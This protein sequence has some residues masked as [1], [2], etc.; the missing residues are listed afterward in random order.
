MNSSGTVENIQILQ[1]G[2]AKHLRQ[3]AYMFS[4]LDR[5]NEV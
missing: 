3:R 2:M 1:G 4:E 5:D